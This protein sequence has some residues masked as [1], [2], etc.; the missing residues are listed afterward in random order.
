MPKIAESTD[1]WLI[2]VNT[3]AQ[4]EELKA[5]LKSRY[6]ENTAVFIHAENKNKEASEFYEELLT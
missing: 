6:G 1:K 5:M 3:I 2:F 4:G